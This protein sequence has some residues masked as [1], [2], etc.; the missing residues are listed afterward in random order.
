M[1]AKGLSSASILIRFARLDGK[2]SSFSILAPASRSIL[3]R[4][5]FRRLLSL[6]AVHLPRRQGP[7]R[8][9]RGIQINIGAQLHLP[10]LKELERRRRPANKQLTDG[11]KIAKAVGARSMR[12]FMGSPLDRRSERP[13]EELMDATI[14]VFKS[15]RAQAQDLN[16][17]RHR[18]PW[19]HDRE[20]RAVIDEADAISSLLA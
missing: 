4:S 7:C 2:I 1:L 13:I 14:K 19:R 11:L 8:S 20:T 12:C 18:K 16:V 6:D 17:N 5:Q 15:V 10:C 9:P 3:F